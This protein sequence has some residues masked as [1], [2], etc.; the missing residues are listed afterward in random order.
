M[1]TRYREREIFKFL[2]TT[3]I[4]QSR[5]ILLR[6]ALFQSFLNEYKLMSF[7]KPVPS[8]SKLKCLN[9]VFDEGLVK[10]EG[11]IRHPNIPN[12]SKHQIILF[13]D[14]PLTQLITSNV[15]CKFLIL[16]MRKR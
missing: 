2:T 7:S 6:Q 14:H 4:N 15:N 16:V 12:E 11:R 9:P 10:V 3:E 1:E 8:N 5:I 13:K